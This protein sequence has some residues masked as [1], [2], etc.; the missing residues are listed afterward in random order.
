MSDV[1]I[2]ATG[3][4]FPEGPVACADGSI[5]LTE[6]RNNRCSRVTRDGQVSLFSATG[7]GIATS[8]KK[9]T[10]CPAKAVFK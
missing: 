9:L 8:P 7:G 1:T 5:V 4:G 6:I 3:L 2:V 10:L